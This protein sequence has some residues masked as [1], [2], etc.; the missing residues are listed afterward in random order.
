WRGLERELRADLEWTQGGNLALA[1][2]PARMALFEEWLA[3]ARQFGLDTRLLRSRD[4]P[5]V[6]PGLGGQWAG[7]MHTPSDGHADPGKSTDALARAAAAHGAT[8]H[9]GCAVEA[10][11]RRNGA[12]SAGLTE[13]GESRTSWVGCAGGAWARWASPCLSAGCAA[14]WPGRRRRPPSP[15]APSGGRAWRSASGRTAPSTSRPAAR[16][17]TTSPSTPC[18]RSGSSFRASGRTRRC[19]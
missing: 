12:G 17:T 18:G 15:P 10:V 16:W 19:S 11:D 5:G 3:V 14:R 9:L 13:R 2:D 1:A 7:G 4:L 8:I 6:V